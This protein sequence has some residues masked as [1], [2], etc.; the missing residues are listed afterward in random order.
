MG[1]V[2]LESA[3]SLKYLDTGC[4]QSSDQTDD[5]EKEQNCN[6]NYWCHPWWLGSIFLKITKLAKL[7]YK[8]LSRYSFYI[9]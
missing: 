6:N 7:S 5:S 2:A 9:F 3:V 1:S 4:P 8:H